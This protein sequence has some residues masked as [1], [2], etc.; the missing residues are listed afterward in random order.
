VTAPCTTPLSPHKITAP[1]PREGSPMYRL[2]L[3]GVAVTSLAFAPAPL[4]RRPAARSDDVSRI[5]GIWVLQAQDRG[6]NKEPGAAD[7]RW[8]LGA[9]KLEIR[10]GGNSYRWEYTIDPRANPRTLDMRYGLNDSVSELK[11]VY[12][13]DGDTLKIGYDTANWGQRPKGL[14]GDG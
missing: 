10:A 2:L 3:I 6:G 5:Q 4:P 13:L 12:S 1:S 11:A 8:V 7:V 9:G 14:E